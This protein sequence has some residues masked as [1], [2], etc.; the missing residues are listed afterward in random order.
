MHPKLLNS[1]KSMQ[2]RRN[3]LNDMEKAKAVEPPTQKKRRHEDK[4]QDP[5]IGS[6]QET[7]KGKKTKDAKPSKRPKS[8]GSSKGATQ[9]QLKST[10]KSVQE[11]LIKSMIGSRNLQGPLLLM[12]ARKS[13]NDGPRQSWLNDLTNVEK[14]P[15]TIDDLMSTPIDFS[16]FAMNRLKISK[17]TKANLVGPVYNLLKRTCKSY[18]ELEYNIEECYRALSDQLD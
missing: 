1:R 7:K 14:P 16:T 3:G 13:V 5:P 15:L 9:S 17:L 10:G 4:D 18:V 6:N 11:K 2:P 12:N 8:T